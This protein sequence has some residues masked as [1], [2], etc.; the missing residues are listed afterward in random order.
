MRA[1]VRVYVFRGVMSVVVVGGG[2]KFN[3]FSIINHASG[4]HTFIRT[5]HTY[6]LLCAVIIFSAIIN[7]L[8]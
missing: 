6:L 7:S 1:Y 3:L 2:A 5:K 4:I 8:N